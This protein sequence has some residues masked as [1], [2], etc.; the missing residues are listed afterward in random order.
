MYNIKS[1]IHHFVPPIHPLWRSSV[2]TLESRW[3]QVTMILNVI[4]LETLQAAGWCSGGLVHQ[5]VEAV[6][7]ATQLP[8]PPL[9]LLRLFSHITSQPPSYPTKSSVWVPWFLFLSSL[10]PWPVSDRVVGLS[11]VSGPV[12]SAARLRV[13]LLCLNWTTNPSSPLA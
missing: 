1:L 11:L 12:C 10:D 3:S 2:V 6:T 13:L 9:L 8:S 7:C 4:L 5:T